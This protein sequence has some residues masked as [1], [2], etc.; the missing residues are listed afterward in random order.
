MD[1]CVSAGTPV[2][3]L[4]NGRLLAAANDII[5]CLFLFRIFLLSHAGFLSFGAVLFQENFSSFAMQYLMCLDVSR[6][7]NYLN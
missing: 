2:G 4:A 7:T 1:K 3:L 5:V 6:S